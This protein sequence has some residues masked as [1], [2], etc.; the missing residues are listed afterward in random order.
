M[1]RTQVFPTVLNAT[2]LNP[3]TYKLGVPL[4]MPRVGCIGDR[5]TIISGGF[6]NEAG[7][8]RNV[9]V[10]DTALPPKSGSTLPAAQSLNATGAVAVAHSSTSGPTVFFDGAV[11]DVYGNSS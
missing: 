9:Y 7:C 3:V 5:Y 11:L 1:A 10:L 8:N 4:K 2:N 6:T